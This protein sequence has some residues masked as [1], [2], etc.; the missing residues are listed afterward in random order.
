MTRVKPLVTVKSDR[1]MAD[2]SARRILEFPGG[3]SIPFSWGRGGSCFRPGS[4]AP[5]L[6]SHLR[7]LASRTRISMDIFA[8]PGHATLVHFYVTTR[9]SPPNAAFP[10]GTLSW[11]RRPSSPFAYLTPFHLPLAARHFRLP[12]FY[13]THPGGGTRR[14]S[15][16]TVIEEFSARHKTHRGGARAATLKVALHGQ[17]K[18]LAAEAR[19]AKEANRDTLPFEIP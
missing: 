8:A 12:F 19:S 16:K 9:V 18:A 10:P 2:P 17:E 5:L 11:P 15:L 3:E 7:P 4:S 6:T 14:N 1:R 13:S